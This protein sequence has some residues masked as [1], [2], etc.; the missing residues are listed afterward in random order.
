[1]RPQDRDPAYLRDILDAARR[2][3]SYAADVGIATSLADNMI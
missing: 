1:M 2:A 3:V